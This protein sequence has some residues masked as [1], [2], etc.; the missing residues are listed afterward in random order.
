MTDKHASPTDFPIYLDRFL[1]KHLSNTK[2]CSSNTFR[3]YCDTFSQLLDF[4]RDHERIDAEQIRLSDFDHNLIES[5]LAYVEQERNCSPATRNVRLSAIH[6]FFRYLQYDH[7]EFL[8]QWGA[9]LAIPFKNTPH[10]AMS[11]LTVEGMTLLLGM[12]D[13]RTSG[14]RRDLALLSLMY[15][16]GCRVQEA[17]DL[18]PSCLRFSKPSTIVI[19]G[20]G[21]KTRIV[22]L[23][24]NLEPILR[25]YM[26]EHGLNEPSAN[27]YP[28]FPNRQGN[29]MTRQALGKI[30]DKHI[31]LARRQRPELIPE[32]FSCHCMRHSL[33][34]HLLQAGIPLIYIRDILGHVSVKTTEVYA[35]VLSKQ[36][37]DALEKA[38]Q[39]L[40]QNQVAEPFWKREKGII[41]WLESFK[42]TSST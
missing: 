33:A 39:H 27:L 7:P 25:S 24:D 37:E 40:A 31:D 35:R 26:Q 13:Q 11:F 41:G 12:P 3:S 42:R 30:L 9:I 6:S 20:K 16:T 15:A 19:T 21:N 8:R 14:G 5:F 34:I 1:N 38:N 18:T 17:C 2:N 29:K 32:T 23:R 36:K 22:P 28:L 4:M 10:K